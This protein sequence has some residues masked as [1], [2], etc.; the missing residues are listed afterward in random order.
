[1][2]D[3]TTYSVPIVFPLSSHDDMTRI[4]CE[5]VQRYINEAHALREGEQKCVNGGGP[6]RERQTKQIQTHRETTEEQLS[7]ERP[8]KQIQTPGQRV[9]QRQYECYLPLR[10]ERRRIEKEKFDSVLQSVCH[11]LSSVNFIQS[12]LSLSAKHSQHPLRESDSKSVQHTESELLYTHSSLPL[13]LDIPSLDSS[14]STFCELRPS[15][16]VSDKSERKSEKI[17]ELSVRLYGPSPSLIGHALH[18]LS[19]LP[20]RVDWTDMY[21]TDLISE[22]LSVYRSETEYALNFLSSFSKRLTSVKHTDTEKIRV[23]ESVSQERAESMLMKEYLSF[24]DIY[25][26]KQQETDLKVNHVALCLSV[27]V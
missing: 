11:A 17:P 25:M 5:S 18:S 2:N 1:M 27:S 4:E 13:S 16:L 23:S 9:K 19:S 8:N 12:P 7:R 21:F 22:F 24:T 15:V 20:L 26:Q 14:L 3:H 10:V 6:L